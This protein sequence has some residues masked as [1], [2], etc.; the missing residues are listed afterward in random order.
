MKKPA[1][2]IIAHLD[3]D[4]RNLIPGYLGKPPKGCNNH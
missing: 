4:L 1:E 2:I 3:P